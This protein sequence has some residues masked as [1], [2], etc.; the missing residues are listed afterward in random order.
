M[1]PQNTAPPCN[2]LTNEHCDV[3]SNALQWCA[4]QDELIAKCQQAGLNVDKYVQDNNR[5]KQMAAGIK[6]AFFPDRP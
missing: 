5:T 6:A 4:F 1:S 2:P 3:L